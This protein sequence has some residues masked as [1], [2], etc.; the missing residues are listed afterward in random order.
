MIELAQKAKPEET[1]FPI[2]DRL[3]MRLI[4]QHY[5]ESFFKRLFA[6]EIHSFTYFRTTISGIFCELHTACYQP[7]EL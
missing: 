3:D 6:S 7:T 1:M 5:P 4:D 2:F